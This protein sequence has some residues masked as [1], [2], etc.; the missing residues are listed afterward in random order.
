MIDKS[1]LSCSS[2]SHAGRDLRGSAC[3]LHE[4]QNSNLSMSPLGETSRLLAILCHC[5]FLEDTVPSLTFFITW[6][7]PIHPSKLHSK[8]SFQDSLLMPNLTYLAWM[9][10][11]LFNNLCHKVLS[12]CLPASV[13]LWALAPVGWGPCHTPVC[14]QVSRACI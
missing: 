6:L 7:T 8:I 1:I 12:I 13:L 11:V 10:S 2:A 3:N 14:Q 5:V 9:Y 4:K